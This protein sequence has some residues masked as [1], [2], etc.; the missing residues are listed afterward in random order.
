MLTARDGTWETAPLERP[1]GRGV[2]LQ[3]LVNNV[4]ALHGWVVAAGHESFL[5]LEKKWYWRTDRMD[6]RTQFG[7]LAPTATSCGLCRSISTAR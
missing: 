6:E 7:V 2:N 5:E 3:F 4:N 1:F